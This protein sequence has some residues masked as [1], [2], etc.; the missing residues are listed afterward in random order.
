MV[1]VVYLTTAILMLRLVITSEKFFLRQI[2]VAEAIKKS[3]VCKDGGMS[4]LF[5]GSALQRMINPA[6]ALT[7]NFV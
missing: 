3:S 5:C 4:C 6:H 1:F 7:S 2:S